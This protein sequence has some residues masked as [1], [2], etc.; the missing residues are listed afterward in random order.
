MLPRQ[1]AAVIGR[2]TMAEERVSPERM[3][4]L[5][6]PLRDLCRLLLSCDARRVAGKAGDK[7]R[8][9]VG[10]LDPA[11]ASLGAQHGC[12]CPALDHLGVAPTLHVSRDGPGRRDHGLDCVRAAEASSEGI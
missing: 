1:P 7:R 3:F 8:H 2:K 4:S 12:S 11:K 6:Y 9:V 5:N 10:S